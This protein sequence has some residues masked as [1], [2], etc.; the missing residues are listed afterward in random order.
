MYTMVCT[1]P[2]LAHAVGVVSMYLLNPGEEYWIIIK[3]IL[4]YLKGKSYLKLALRGT[5]LTLRGYTNF[6]L[7][8]DIDSRKSTSG[9]LITFSRGALSWDHGNLDIK[10]A[11]Y[12]LLQKQ[13]L[14]Q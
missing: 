10:N 8:G 11:L 3:W 4:T 14:L 9:Y 5:E 12:C 1:R 6:D 7:G 2:D 13:N